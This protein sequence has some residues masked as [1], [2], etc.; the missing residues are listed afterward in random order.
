VKWDP[1]RVDSLSP[2]YIKLITLG[3]GWEEPGSTGGG[4]RIHVF[5][6]TSQQDVVGDFG[7][8]RQF[9]N[10]VPANG[11]YTDDIA[12]TWNVDMTNATNPDSNTLGDLFRPGID[13]VWV[14]WD[15]ELM[16]ITHGVGMWDAAGRFM[17]LTDEDANMIYTGTYT[18]HQS[19]KY[20]HGWFQLGYRIAYSTADGGRVVHGNGVDR[21]RRYLQYIHPDEI[22]PGTPWPLPQWPAE[23]NLPVVSWRKEKLFTEY[24]PPD[25]TQPT[26]ISNPDNVANTYKL[27]QNYPNPFN[28]STSIKYSLAKAGNVSI[29]IYNIAGQLVTT[30]LNAQQ[31]RGAHS[32][33]WSG[34]NSKGENVVSGIYFVKLVAG[35]FSSVKKMTLLR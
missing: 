25:L 10:S 20:P 8:D 28:P 26:G 31:N 7:F 32:I 34:K 3:N 15:G 1:S 23:Y 14:Q 5:Q 12:I 19:T 9:F 22:L 2:N 18:M 17:M 13:T 11:V 24:P 16:G 30:L 21:G 29:K 33:N 6:N 4:N 27:E 35:D